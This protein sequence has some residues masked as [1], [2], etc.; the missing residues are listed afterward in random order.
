MTIWI[1][2]AVSML[3]IVG[4]ILMLRP[5]PRERRLAR[6]REV[7]QQHRVKIQPLFL[8]RDPVYAAT[9]ERNL[10]LADHDWARYQLVAEEKQTGPSVKGKWVQRRTPQ[11]E[12]VWEAQDIRQTPVPAVDALLARW[13]AAQ[14]PDFLALELGPRS[15]SLVWNEKGDLAEV[16]AVCRQLQELLTV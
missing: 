2:I 4:P 3:F 7:A 10:H 16:E 11:G 12:L 5:S 14:S 6:I 8:R 13:H 9:L 15:A 1:I